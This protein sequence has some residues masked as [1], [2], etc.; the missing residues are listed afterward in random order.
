MQQLMKISEDLLPKPGEFNEKSSFFKQEVHM[1]FDISFVF[2][3]FSLLI[4][5]K[6][7]AI[8]LVI[9]YDVHNWFL[10]FPC[11]LILNSGVY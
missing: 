3:C 11:L 7:K 8:T 4:Q 5:K 10:K 2:F 1:G 9:I 6:K